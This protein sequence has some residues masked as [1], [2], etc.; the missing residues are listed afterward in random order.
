MA[1]AK[2]RPM[3]DQLVNAAIDLFSTKGYDATSVADIQT[4]CGL[5]AGSGALYKHFPSKEELL[6][7]VLRRHV[8]GIAHD[9]EEAVANPPEGLNAGLRYLAETVWRS[10]ERDRNVVRITLRDLD[11]F[12]DLV[13]ELWDST[14]RNVYQ[15]AALVIRHEKEQGRIDVADPEATAAVLV[16]SLTYFPILEGLIGRTPGDVD[17]GRFLNAWV[18]SAH[19]TLAAPAPS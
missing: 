6:R 8:T 3:R 15:Q 16:A 11:P 13:D 19:R 4:A 9:R 2:S 18:D 1:P 17:R 5:T 7:E 14:L 10:M 12:P